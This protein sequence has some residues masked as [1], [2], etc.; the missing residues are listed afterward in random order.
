MHLSVILFRSVSFS[1]QRTRRWVATESTSRIADPKVLDITS[2][3][4]S[5]ADFLPW[6]ALVASGVVGLA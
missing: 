3:A 5:L 1:S 2:H 4:Q 6:A